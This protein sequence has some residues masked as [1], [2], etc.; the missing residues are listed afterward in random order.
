MTFRTANNSLVGHQPIATNSTTKNH[1]LGSIISATDPT[2]GSGEFI[3]L[4]GVASTVAGS[5][6]VYD[7]SFQTALATSALDEPRPM[8]VSVAATVADE[9]GWYQISG[10][11]Y[12][13]KSGSLCLVKGGR[14]GVTAGAVVAAA[15]GNLVNGAVV[16]VTASVVS[17]AE[18]YVYI[19]CNRP[20]GPSDLS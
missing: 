5:I 9:Y 15:T 14:F 4:K 20:H 1:P 7:D 12:A 2:Y 8:A 10:I 19:M 16:A 13:S 18:A 17:P 11:A 6:V 3:Y